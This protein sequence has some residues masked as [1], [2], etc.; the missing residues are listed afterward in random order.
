[1]WVALVNGVLFSVAPFVVCRYSARSRDH[2]GSNPRELLTPIYFLYAL[3]V[4]F[5]SLIVLLRVHFPSIFYWF[6]LVRHFLID[7]KI[8]GKTFCEPFFFSWWLWAILSLI[9]FYVMC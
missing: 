3:A 1:M 2:V 6:G 4:F 8:F 9:I 7:T 5:V